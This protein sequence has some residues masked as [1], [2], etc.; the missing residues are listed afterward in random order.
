MYLT[1]SLNY[2]GI[3][4]EKLKDFVYLMLIKNSNLSDQTH[5]IPEVFDSKQILF[6]TFV[7]SL[8]RGNIKVMV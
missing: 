5:L 4:E 6:F 7:Y 3:P 1:R 2:R 8:A